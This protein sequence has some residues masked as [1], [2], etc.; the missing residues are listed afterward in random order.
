M[1]QHNHE[2]DPK[3]SLNRRA[4]GIATQIA[5]ENFY[6]SEH[7]VSVSFKREKFSQNLLLV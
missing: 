5:Q 2:F 3:F 6:W 1:N 7:D 4:I